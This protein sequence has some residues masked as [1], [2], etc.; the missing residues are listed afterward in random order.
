V[1]L[2]S[3]GIFGQ[4]SRSINALIRKTTAAH[5]RVISGVIDLNHISHHHAFSILYSVNLQK[6]KTLF[7]SSK[8]FEY[9][10]IV[11]A[12]Q[13]ALDL[14]FT[15]V[16]LS[17]N[18]VDQ[19][20]G[21]E[22]ICI[23]TSDDASADVLQELKKIGVKHVV[24]RS[25]GFNNIHLETAAQ[26]GIT[27]AYAPDC[28]PEAVAEHTIA[29]MLALGRHLITANRQTRRNDFTLSN[30]VGFNLQGKKVGIIGTGR[31]GSAVARILHGFECELMGYDV[32]YNENL[33]EQYHLQYT[34]LRELCKRADIITI[35]TPLT[36][37]TRYLIDSD[38]LEDVQHGLMLINTS[39]G[40]V[41]NTCAVLNALEDGII[42]SL[43][44]D[45]YENEKEIFFTNRTTNPPEDPIFLKL[46]QMPNVLITPHQAFA[47]QEALQKIADTTIYNLQCF[48][49]KDL[50]K[51]QLTCTVE[52]ITKSPERA[53]MLY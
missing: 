17:L 30:L 21:C 18:T 8:D 20:E 33:V 29:L 31:I 53:Y 52:S 13:Q 51:Y 23:F 35:H 26:L 32:H 2:A 44:L 39:R 36:R 46:M 15:P 5:L 6:M 40:M 22:A 10:F 43:G 38:F 14:Q 3:S 47:T 4:V 9:P 42:G 49:S 41:L 45:V 11:A 37:Q 34:S 7:Y 48:E 24:L 16:S 28:S 50:S 19:A 12:N 1:P 25:G 27:V